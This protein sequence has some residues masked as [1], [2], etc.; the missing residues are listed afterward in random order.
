MRALLAV[1]ATLAAHSVWAQE[2][3]PFAAFDLASEAIL[4][5]PHDLA[6]GPDG[7]L[8]V[9]DKFGNRITVFDP[10]TLTV[11]RQFAEGQLSGVHDIS[12]WP[13]GSALI[14][15]TGQSL[16]IKVSDVT[17]DEIA[18]ELAYSAPRVEGAL[19]HSSGR[20]FV[21]A[22]G[23][24]VLAVF[25]GQEVIATVSGHPGAHDVAEAPDGNI[26]LADN[27]YSRLVEYSPDLELL[28]TFDH[29]KY[30]FIGPPYLDIDSFGRLIVADQYAH[31]VLLIDPNQGEDGVLIGILGTGEPGM[32]PNRF[33]DPEG[34]AIWNN[35][36]FISDSDN[37][38]I[39]R[40]SVVMN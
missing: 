25:D 8:Y 28:R 2:V 39:V 40:Y 27:A 17:A 4:N 18:I 34:V 11:V 1:I 32:G 15:V 3:Q 33:D 24:G 19:A 23:I 30:G 26:W 29:A 22:S 14:A 10:E 16:A 21:M 13:D 6:I 35:S 38:R 36:Y 9:A 31:R 12:F 7:L 20:S 5:D 37:Y